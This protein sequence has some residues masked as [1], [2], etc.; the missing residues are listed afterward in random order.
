MSTHRV[1]FKDLIEEIT[2]LKVYPV[3]IPQNAKY[4]CIQST[5]S[6]GGRDGDSNLA[7][8][9]IKEYRLSIVV[10]SDKVS[11]NDEIETKLITA[12]DGNT[13]TSGDTKS[14]VFRH[15]NTTELYNYT[16]GLHEMTIEFTTKTLS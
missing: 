8:S 16:Q 4:P 5:I 12:L 14:L 6:G 10:C 2:G 11:I 15:T 13:I 1:D 9:N 7:N 3:I